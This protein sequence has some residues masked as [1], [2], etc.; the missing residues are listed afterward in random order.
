MKREMGLKY[1]VIQAR[2][3]VNKFNE[4]QLDDFKQLAKH[5]KTLGA[6]QELFEQAKSANTANEVLELAQEAG[7]P[8]ANTI[9]QKAGLVVR[10]ALRDAKTELNI[11]IITGTSSANPQGKLVGE[12][13]NNA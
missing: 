5:L 12:A 8:L 4:H 2:M 13:E 11:M 7:L 3:I 6:N 10:K 1:P 9:A